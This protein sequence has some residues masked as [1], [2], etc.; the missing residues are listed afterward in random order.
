MELERLLQWMEPSLD[1]AFAPPPFDST[2]AAEFLP[3]AGRSEASH[4][5]LL[6]RW[7]GFYA[8]NGLLHV[9]GACNAPP[10]HSIRV[11]NAPD[12]WRRSWGRLTEGLTFFGES[13]FG[14]QFAYRGGKIVRFKSLEGG[15]DALQATIDEWLEACLLDPEFM[16]HQRVYDACAAVH[17]PVPY[18]GHFAPTGQIKSIR[19]LTPQTVHVVPSRDSME[20]KS[21]AA[22]NVVSRST[23]QI[24]R[25][26]IRK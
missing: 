26:P 11:W 12:G 4:R 19:D 16:L 7:N 2:I 22:S 18:G 13:A 10:N 21:V 6:Q 20:L 1:T 14:D 25:A 5:A 9:F 3:V 15:I 23:S 17:G 8:L 24:M